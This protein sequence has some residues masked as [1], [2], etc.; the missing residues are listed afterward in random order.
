MSVVAIVQ[1]RMG[2]SRLPGKVMKKVLGRP[3]L[4][5]L[6]D[7]LR[8]SKLIDKIVIATTSKTA[9]RPILK[10]AQKMGVDSFTGSEDDV[11]DRYYQAAIK[12]D[13]D[14][15]VRITADCP[16]IDPEL[17]D[18]IIEHYLK[19]R[20]HLDYAQS[21][22]SFPDGIVETA[23]FSFAA[24]ERTWKEA[25]LSSEREHV[26]SYIWT[27]PHLFR[28]ATIENSENLSNIRLT[29]DNE[30]DFQLVSKLL[31]AL[32]QEGEIFHLQDMMNYLRRNPELLELN[33]HIGR[34]E[35]YLKSL[36]ED[37]CIW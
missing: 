11:L 37:K 6:I 25:K 21:G 22:L 27:N 8:K 20:E 33:K 35:G 34:N 19:N 31:Q 26:T 9:D 4:W 13:K 15:I 32:Y 18:K 29:V 7:R 3:L 2:S 30:E 24:L 28:I 14:T 10:L 12:Y 23:V 36:A 17:V 5:Y 16:L 1:A